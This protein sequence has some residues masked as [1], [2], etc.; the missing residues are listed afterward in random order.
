MVDPEAGHRAFIRQQRRR[1]WVDTIIMLVLFS[2]TFGWYLSGVSRTAFHQDESRWLNRAHYLTDLADPFGPTWN[3]QYL[4]RG[5]PPVGSYMMG[6]GLLLQGRDLETN[7]AWDFRRN[8]SFNRAIGAMPDRA[9]QLAGRRW[10]SFLGAVAVACVY[11]IVR[12]L[13][14]PIGGVVGAAFLIANPL[15]TWQN[16]IALADTTLTL[17]LALLFLVV[18]RLM[19]RPSWWYALAAGVLIGLGGAN[20]LTPIA[21]SIPLALVGVLLLARG[22][23]DRRALTNRV[24]P[25]PLGLPSFRDV[26][27]MLLS[28]PLTA[29]TTFVVVYPYL[30]PSPIMRTLT[31]IHFRQQEMQGQIRMSPAL[32]TDGPIQALI[33]TVTSLGG[34]PDSDGK[35]STTYKVF[36]MIGLPDVGMALS[37][38]D[39]VLAVIGL[40][41]ITVVGIRKGIRSAELMI[42]ALIVFQTLTIVLN[43]RV[44][45]ERYFLPILLGEVV[46][47]GCAI[48]YLIGPLL[49]TSRIPFAPPSSARAPREDIAS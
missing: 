35:W 47:I 9:D 40:A 45:F 17:T 23:Y 27:W 1:R 14:N 4:T 6:L 28:I 26:G 41:L 7:P 11:L 34:A 13:T 19:R 42:A 16:R 49:P 43:M 32:A 2:V 24:S 3:D 25:G 33:R 22:W 38:T 31:L 10:N 37:Y 30:W 29:L 46:V 44:A 36:A 39:I 15:Q 48:G 12:R 5:Q 18:I 20:K 21:L 8:S